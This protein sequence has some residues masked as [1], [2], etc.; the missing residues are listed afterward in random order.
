MMPHGG[1]DVRNLFQGTSLALIAVYI[2]ALILIGV[3]SISFRGS[4]VV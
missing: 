2:G 4:V 1:F 3:L